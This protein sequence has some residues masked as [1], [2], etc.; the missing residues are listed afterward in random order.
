MR[1]AVIV[2]TARTPIGKAYRGAF[3]N[4][5]SQAL[6]GHAIK[7]AIARA[8]IDPAEVEDVV[9]GAAL[10][11]GSAFQNVARQALLR[12]GVS[13]VVPGQ[14]IDRQCA[15]G[16]MAIATAAKQVVVDNMQIAVG[17][18]V[19]LAP[20]LL[21]RVRPLLL[22][23]LANYVDSPVLLER[24]DEYLVPAATGADAGVIGAMLLA[25]QALGE[26]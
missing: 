12:A 5:T 14:S 22:K 2:S 11:Q 16:M 23:S 24:I 13:H 4:T 17:G 10:Q 15:S 7:H 3:N 21:E 6:G 8:K 25:E 1:E 20:G 9:F 18:G 26:K 19:G